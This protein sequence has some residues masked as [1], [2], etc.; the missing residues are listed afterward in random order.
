MKVTVKTVLPHPPEAIFDFVADMR[1]D[2]QWAPLVQDVVQTAGQ[3]PGLGARYRYTQH[4]GGHRIEMDATVTVY[5]RPRRLRWSV[6]HKAMDYEATMVFKPHAKGTRII[7]TNFE[8]W[9]FAPWWLRIMG[10]AL[11]KKQL[12]RQLALLGQAL[13]KERREEETVQDYLDSNSA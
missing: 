5:E 9:L 4:M 11:V 2:E 10:P 6:D 3:R 12:R 7:Q 1:N 13:A 8:R